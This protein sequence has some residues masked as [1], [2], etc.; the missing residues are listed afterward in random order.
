MT[1]FYCVGYSSCYLTD[2]AMLNTLISRLTTNKPPTPSKTVRRR[3]QASLKAF[4]VLLTVLSFS[5]LP[6]QQSAVAQEIAGINIETGKF[7]CSHPGTV[8]MY[9]AVDALNT[10]ASLGITRYELRRHY[11]EIQIL[12][13]HASREGGCMFVVT[14]LDLVASNY[15]SAYILSSGDMGLLS[16]SSDLVQAVPEDLKNQVPIFTRDGQSYVRAIDLA[17]FFVIRASRRFEDLH[18][19]I[20]MVLR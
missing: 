8:A 13:P 11:I 2:K 1:S 6:S 9:K 18:R 4:I 17:P 12:R 19:R 7:I 3:S 15:N 20:E 14:D 16:W 5:Y 10:R